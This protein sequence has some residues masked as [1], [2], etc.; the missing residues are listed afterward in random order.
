MNELV[1]IV[2]WIIVAT[3]ITLFLIFTA[4]IVFFV[5]HTTRKKLRQIERQERKQGEKE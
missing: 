2:A 3:M 4:G 5:S 1:L